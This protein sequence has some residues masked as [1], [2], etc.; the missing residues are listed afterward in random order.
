MPV[1]TR[2]KTRT[3]SLSAPAPNTN[4]TQPPL[5]TSRSSD[6]SP[7]VYDGTSILCAN[8]TPS[9]PVMTLTPSLLHESSPKRIYLQQ[10]L[11]VLIQSHYLRLLFK[12]AR[13]DNYCHRPFSHL[14]DILISFF[15]TVGYVSNRFLESSSL[16]VKVFFETFSRPV[17]MQQL[18]QL[19]YMASIFKAK[20][21]SVC[22]TV[23][24][25]TLVKDIG[26][27]TS[28]IT[29]L[30]SHDGC[31]L[32][33]H[34]LDPSSS[35]FLPGLRVL[36]VTNKLSNDLFTSFCK[37]LTVNNTV[38]E[39][40]LGIDSISSAEAAS[41]AEVF[42][43][44]K[45]LRKICLKSSNSLQDEESLIIFTAISN[46]VVISKIDLTNLRIKSS[47][48]LL[49]LLKSSSLRSVKFPLNCRLDSFVFD[50]LK[51]NSNIREVVIQN[52]KFDSQDLTEI[53][54]CNTSLKKLEIGG[55]LTISL[56]KALETNTSLLE[57]VVHNSNW[58]PNGSPI[59]DQIPQSLS[60]LL[61]RNTS[62]A[63]LNIDCRF[64][65]SS[66]FK[67]FLKGFEQNSTVKKVILPELN[68]ACLML[69][70]EAV[71]N[72]KLA[73]NV[74]VSH[75]C[76]DTTKSVFS[77]IPFGR[78]H[79]SLEEISSLP[80][81][82]NSF[83]VKELT[84]RRC[85]FA[86]EAFTAFCDSI[87]VNNSLTSVDFSDN[88]ICQ[89]KS[90]GRY[91]TLH[92]ENF[93]KMIDALQCKPNIK[94]VIL[95]GSS[96]GFKG[97]CTVF[98]LVSAN[99][100]TPNIEISPH[101]F[102]FATGSISYANP[103]DNSDLLVLLDSLKSNVPIKRVKCKQWPRPSLE[104]LATVFEI[105]SINK[106]VIDL[107]ISP[108]LLDVE[109]G[110][111]RYL[112]KTLTPITVEQASSLQSLLKCSNLKELTLKR[113]MC[114]SHELVIP[115]AESLRH[116]T[117][118]TFVDFSHLSMYNKSFKV[119]TDALAVHTSVTEIHFCSSSISSNTKKYIER[120]LNG[121]IKFVDMKC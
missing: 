9:P 100:L 50:V 90:R 28:I 32:L 22:V 91:D 25:R 20:V 10:S 26:E 87:R 83:N 108:H 71:Y 29:H 5:K 92:D 11:L 97:P 81:F 45:T 57:F 16:A 15:Q 98:E 18:P 38:V 105:L 70:F 34:F 113:L 117:S 44:N 72:G 66:Q 112:P 1:T 4:L 48:V 86:F 55:P 27:F 103:I 63:V 41:L 69:V 49:P 53:L 96:V 78:I 39:F 68:F 42:S 12:S 37:S 36:E 121:R 43:L 54:K 24:N 47:N 107:D 118:L 120:K 116:N 33:H 88:Q 74:D 51:I 58:F 30:K 106:S 93:L 99:Q 2:S 84:L 13:K 31:C 61:R 114:F 6:D 46:N 77:F 17:M 85:W 111:F 101:S 40:H 56:C 82:L 60:E 3:T 8:S 104:V 95:N 52:C 67:T 19:C 65:S 94:Q 119:L 64:A 35:D 109:K 21:H 59:N 102:D 14:R 73:S 75:N 80:G 89:D 115:L 7:S 23:D 62:L 110:V 79:I 76:I